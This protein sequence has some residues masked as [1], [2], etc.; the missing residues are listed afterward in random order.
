MVKLKNVTCNFTAANSVISMFLNLPCISEFLWKVEIG[1]RLPVS[2]T[3]YRLCLQ[4][5]LFPDEVL[6]STALLQAMHIENATN[7]SQFFE[8]L[9]VALL[10]EQQMELPAFFPE[11]AFFRQAIEQCNTCSATTETPSCESHF[12]LAVS[13]G[14]FFESMPVHTI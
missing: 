13:L 10:S 3:F 1:D 14:F 8:T 5:K 4:N 11:A 2:S 7:P 6:D 12:L 9:M